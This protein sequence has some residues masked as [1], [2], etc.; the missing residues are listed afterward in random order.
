MLLFGLAKGR[1]MKTSN[2]KEKNECEV[3][4]K[5]FNQEGVCDDCGL[6][7]KDNFIKA[8]EQAVPEKHNDL[9]IP[10]LLIQMN[11]MIS[12]GWNVYIKWQCEACHERVT[13]ETPNTFFK[14][15]FVHTEKADGT[16]CGHTSF[17]KKFGMMIE[18]ELRQ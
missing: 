10:E 13:C 9:E 5:S 3:C 11:K 14:E 15:G 2:N 7:S 1:T 16:S 18:R 6:P 17:P 12:Q 4:G 8:L